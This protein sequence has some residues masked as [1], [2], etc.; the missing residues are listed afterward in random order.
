ML[1]GL[2]GFLLIVLGAGLMAAYGLAVNFIEIHWSVTFALPAVY[3]VGSLFIGV[4]IL[5][6]FIRERVWYCPNCQQVDKR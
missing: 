4:G 3:Y 6:F 5:F 1:S 2:C